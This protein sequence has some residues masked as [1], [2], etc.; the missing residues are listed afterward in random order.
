MYQEIQKKGV[1]KKSDFQD[2]LTHLFSYR[3]VFLKKE[4]AKFPFFL[5]SYAGSYAERSGNRRQDADSNLND[6]FPSVFFHGTDSLLVFM[7]K[8][9]TIVVARFLQAYRA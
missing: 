2:F 4:T 9:N 8:M 6:G 1:S 3:V 5:L 7:E